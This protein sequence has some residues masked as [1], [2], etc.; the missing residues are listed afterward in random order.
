MTDMEELTN[1]QLVEALKDLMRVHIA[2]T[3]AL[4]T[5]VTCLPKDLPV[6]TEAKLLAMHMNVSKAGRA[7]LKRYPFLGPLSN[8]LAA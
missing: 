8:D 1:E 5:T 2:T 3:I 4:V 6:D 7:L